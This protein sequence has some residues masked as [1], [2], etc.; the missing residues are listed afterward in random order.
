MDIKVQEFEQNGHKM[1]ASIF[2]VEDFL[3]ED[4]VKADVWNRTN[5][6]GYQ[7]ELV[8]S[9]GKHF[10]NFIKRKNYSPLSILLNVRGKTTFK[11]QGAGQGT[12]TI[13]DDSIL[14]IVDGQHRITGYRLAA[15]TDD[16]LRQLQVPVIIINENSPYEELIQFFVINRTQKGVK[17]DLA[18]ETLFKL[19]DNGEDL[20]D[21]LPGV[22]TR[23]MDWIP[24]ANNVVSNLND[25]V[26]SPWHGLI[27]FST[28]SGGRVRVKTFVDSLKPIL[29]GH[30]LPEIDTPEEWTKILKAYWSTIRECAPEAF[31]FP[32]EYVLASR[33]GLFMFHRLFPVVANYCLNEK[34]QYHFSKEQF[35]K[36]LQGMPSLQGSETW[37]KETGKIGT[38]GTSETTFKGLLAGLKVE[39][40]KANTKR[41]G[42]PRTYVI[43]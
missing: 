23:G 42:K 35:E 22:L 37:A 38:S 32:E 8:L 27:K 43:E 17:P 26:D 11:P 15:E 19:K 18:Y 25:N 33:T 1:Y 10:A 3:D 31:E 13:P 9:R 20:S 40:V 14:W 41:A 6:E 36:I 7:R 30:L 39:L 12:L 28:S 5:A 29:E 24:V 34:G 21:R 2:K 4:K 16:D